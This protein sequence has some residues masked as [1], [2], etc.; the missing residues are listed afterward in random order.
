MM[1]GTKHNAYTEDD[2]EACMVLFQEEL[3]HHERM[4]RVNLRD[5]TIM[6]QYV[7]T[8]GVMAA[9]RQCMQAVRSHRIK[10]VNC[11][12]RWTFFAKRQKH[13]RAKARKG[14]YEKAI[15]DAIGELREGR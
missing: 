7:Q 6:D 10:A 13:E 1:G 11:V 15:A 14:R 2:N 8:P 5:A 9:K 12:Q 3:Q 4:V